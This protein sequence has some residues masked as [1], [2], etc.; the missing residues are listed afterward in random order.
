MTSLSVAQTNQIITLLEKQ[1][2][3]HQISAYTGLNHSSISRVCSKPWSGL[4]KNRRV[5]EVLKVKGG[6]T[7]Y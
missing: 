7:S 2:S 5:Q 1:Q 3:T 4:S 6:Y